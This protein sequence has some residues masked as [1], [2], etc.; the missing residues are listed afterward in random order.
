MPVGVESVEKAVEPLA[1]SV[2]PLAVKTVLETPEPHVKT[3]D[4]TPQLPLDDV[5]VK[6]LPDAVAVYVAH[7][8]VVYQ[9]PAEIRHPFCDPPEITFR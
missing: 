1:M 7:V 9:V 3:P 5:R 6:P 8:P 4:T 2:L